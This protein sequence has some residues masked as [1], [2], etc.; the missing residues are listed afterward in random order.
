MA[1][2]CVHIP[3][4]SRRQLLHQPCNSDDSMQATHSEGALILNYL[5]VFVIY[6]STSN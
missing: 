6:S 5:G 1:A 3:D 2:E 4:I